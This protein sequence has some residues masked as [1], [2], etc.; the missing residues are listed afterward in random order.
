MDE[1]AAMYPNLAKNILIGRSYEGRELKVMHISNGP[2]KKA[3][4]T[5]GAIHAREWLAPCVAM[6]IIYELVENY[7]QNQAYVDMV[8]WFVLPVANPDGYNFS[9]TDVSIIVSE[10]NH[11][12]SSTT[13]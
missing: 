6:K 1:V 3:I 11:F 4:F 7:A 9:W 13:I 8:D 2:G 12:K 10:R 5:D